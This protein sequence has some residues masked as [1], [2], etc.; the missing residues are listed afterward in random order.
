MLV[1]VISVKNVE[2]LLISKGFKVQHEKTFS[3]FKKGRDL[4]LTLPT[5]FFEVRPAYL[6][7]IATQLDGFYIMSLKD[8]HHWMDKTKVKKKATPELL[9]KLGIKRLPWKEAKLL[10]A[11]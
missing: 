3:I 7:A 1:D 2:D 5:Q 10:M 8:F 6:Q 9:H 4:Y 11:S